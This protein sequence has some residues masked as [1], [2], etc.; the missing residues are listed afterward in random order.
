MAQTRGPLLACILLAALIAG[1]QSEVR[2]QLAGKWIEQNGAVWEFTQDG[3]VVIKGDAKPTYALLD[4]ATL[5]IEF[6]DSQSLAVT[7]KYELT[8]QKLILNP[9]EAS[10]DG[11]LPRHWDEPTV[12][13]RQ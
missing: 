11:A 7:Y 6:H 13:V 3:I 5:K 4:E 2:P 12:L 10:G 8:E 9:E 1:C